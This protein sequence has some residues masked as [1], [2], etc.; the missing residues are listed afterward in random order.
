MGKELISKVELDH[1]VD[2][3]GDE[4]TAKCHEI[5]GGIVFVCVMNGAFMFYSDLVKHIKYPIIVC[6]KFVKI[7]KTFASTFFKYARKKISK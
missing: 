2:D 3:L 6:Q 5:G 1:L 7:N 4:L